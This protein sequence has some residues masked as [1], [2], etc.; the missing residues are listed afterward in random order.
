MS[1]NRRINLKNTQ[2]KFLPRQEFNPGMPVLLHL[3]RDITDVDFYTIFLKKEQ[4]TQLTVLEAIL[5]L[6]GEDSVKVNTID[7]CL[8]HTYTGII[9]F[10]NN[11]K[12]EQG[13]EK[14]KFRDRARY[15][16]LKVFHI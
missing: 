6:L 9:D 11:E 16:R 13:E 15:Y 2:I 8:R 3:S 14:N 10:D 5:D 12:I 4:V 7:N 1:H